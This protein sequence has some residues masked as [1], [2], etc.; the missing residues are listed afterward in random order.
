MLFGRFNGVVGLAGLLDKKMSGI[1]SGHKKVVVLTGWSFGGV[2]L[3]NERF[4]GR[5]FPRWLQEQR[6]QLLVQQQEQ[7]LLMFEEQRRR[8]TVG[9]QQQAASPASSSYSTGGLRAMLAD[10]PQEGSSRQT[11]TLLVGKAIAFY[12]L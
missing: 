9:Q 2:S 7:R 8:E 4:N 3:D 6:R 10:D 5:S 1:C 11:G 12:I